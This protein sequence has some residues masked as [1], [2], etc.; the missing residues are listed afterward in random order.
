MTAKFLR[1]QPR[2]GSLSGEDGAEPGGRVLRL[3]RRGLQDGED[4]LF[5]EHRLELAVLEHF[6][7]D[8]AAADNSP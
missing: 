1:T 2:R 5:G 7:D 6:A 4:A 8:V 3:L